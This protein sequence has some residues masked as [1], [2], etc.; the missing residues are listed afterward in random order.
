MELVFPELDIFELSFIFGFFWFGM[1]V[2]EVA[3]ASY[4]TSN[5]LIGAQH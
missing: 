4:Y 5:L 2:L 3:G 1:L